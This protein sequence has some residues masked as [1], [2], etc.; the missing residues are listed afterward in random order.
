MIAAKTM[1]ANA[2]SIPPPSVDGTTDAPWLLRS[3]NRDSG[4]G[5]EKNIFLEE[6]RD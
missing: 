3:D 1:G 4:T 5:P 2:S 6:R